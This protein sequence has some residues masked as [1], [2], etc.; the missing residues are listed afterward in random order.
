VAGMTNLRN[1]VL[2][3]EESTKSDNGTTLDFHY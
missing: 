3:N 2:R 1:S